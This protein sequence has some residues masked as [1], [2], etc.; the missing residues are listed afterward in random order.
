MQVMQ[1]E[2]L[3]YLITEYASG[4]EIFGEFMFFFVVNFDH[5]I[6]DC[7]SYL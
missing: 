6:N 7:A 2:R 1:T 3:I 5:L 4:G